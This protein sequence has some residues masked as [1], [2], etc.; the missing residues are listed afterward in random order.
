M[1]SLA[2]ESPEESPEEE[3]SGEGES[4]DQFEEG[5]E[6]GG[7]YNLR[8]RQPVIYHFQPVHHVKAF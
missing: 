1:T 6:D 3:K 7:Y 5:E 8:K 4:E 2:E